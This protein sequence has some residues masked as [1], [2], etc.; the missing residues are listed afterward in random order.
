MSEQK[1]KPKSNIAEEFDVSHDEL[2]KAFEEFVREEPPREQN[3]GLVNFATVTGGVMLVVVLFSLLQMIGLDVGPDISMMMHVMPLVGGLLVLIL[4]LGWFSRRRR[5]KKKK[6]NVNEFPEFKLKNQ[7]KTRG[8]AAAATGFDAYGYRKKKKLFRSR[9]NKKVLG[10]CGGI[11]DYFGLD[12]TVVRIIFALSLVFYGSTILV[13]LALGIFLQ[14]EPPKLAG[15]SAE[16]D[17]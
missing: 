12:P 16:D 17:N 14:K 13:Y 15:Y 9:R 6:V 3:K 1:T 10:V 5:K 4:G 8:S 11:A 2:V 7:N